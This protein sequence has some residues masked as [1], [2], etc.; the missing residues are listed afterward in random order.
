[1]FPPIPN[2]FYRKWNLYIIAPALLLMQKPFAQQV[3]LCP[4]GQAKVSTDAGYVERSRVAST[5]QAG[6]DLHRVLLS[7]P[8]RQQ[9][10]PSEV[11]GLCKMKTAQARPALFFVLPS[12]VQ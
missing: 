8:G 6:A 10:A 2:F 11:A 3:V 9:F 12:L 1:M 5:P 7:S 4:F